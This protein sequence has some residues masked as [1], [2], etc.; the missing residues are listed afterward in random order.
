MKAFISLCLF[1]LSSYA[2]AQQDSALLV[3]HIEENQKTQ[4]LYHLM[5]VNYYGLTCAD[6]ALRGKLFFVSIDEYQKGNKTHHFDLGLTEGIDTIKMV[7]GSGEA[8]YYLMDH[9]EHARYPVNNKEYIMDLMSKNYGDSTDVLI[10]LP[11]I[12]IPIKLK[13]NI[14]YQLRNI[15]PCGSS[16]SIR[17]PLSVATPIL[18]FTPGFALN[19]GGMYYCAL[20]LK[21]VK[22]WYKEYKIEHY[23]VFN[24]LV[25]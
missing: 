2:Y 24:L 23:Y 6:T 3:Y 4:M 17:I 18:A 7:N 8:F 12:H 19:N 25:K 13:G 10:Y 15:N 22:D 14:E 20:G 21:D 5:G 16:D 1:I 9:S 11:N